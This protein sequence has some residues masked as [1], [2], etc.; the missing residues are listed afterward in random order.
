MSAALETLPPD[1]RAVLQLILKQGRGY[2]DLS[3]LL[4]IDEAAVRARAHAGL[5][6]LVTDGSGAALTPGRRAQIADWLLGQQSPGDRAVT[7]QHLQDSRAARRWATALRDQL[8]PLAQGHELPELPAGRNGAAA[9]ARPAAAAP[10][11]AP[12]VTPHDDA[13]DVGPE[14]VAAAAAPT[15]PTTDRADDGGPAAEQ[16]APPRTTDDRRER[17]QAR[18]GDPGPAPARPTARDFELEPRRSSKLGGALLLVGLA[19]LVAV[20]LIVVLGGGDDDGGGGS[21][22]APPAAQTTAQQERTGGAASTE[23]TVLQQVNLFPPGGRGAGEARGIAFIMSQDGRPIV[24]VQTSGVDPNSTSDVY[25]AWLTSRAT[26]RARFLGY[27]PN[28]VRDERRF[29]VSAA[30]PRDTTRYD[31]VVVS[32]ESTGTTEAPGSPTDVVLV[33]TL[34]VNRVG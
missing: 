33:G 27:V 1:Q 34:R 7:L 8:A 14:P 6:A 28:F 15:A 18:A 17:E 20:V 24:A 32:R 9:D 3:G 2:A 25:A 29:T 26:G 16:A 31:Q 21:A 10:P 12:A 11:A 22:T 30:L 23:P 5:D 4:K 13:D 19:A